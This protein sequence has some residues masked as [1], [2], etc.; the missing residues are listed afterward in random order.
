MFGYGRASDIPA[1][2]AQNDHHVKQSKRCARHDKHIDGSDTLGL[3][4]QEA[5]PGR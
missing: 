1:I 4:A 2:V 3:I 5:T